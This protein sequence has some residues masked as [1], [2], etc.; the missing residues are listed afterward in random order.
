MDRNKLGKVEFLDKY[1]VELCDEDMVSFL[2]YGVLECLDENNKDH[3][4]VDFL[5]S[6]SF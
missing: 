3:F 1:E 4:D 5:H 6:H 2:D